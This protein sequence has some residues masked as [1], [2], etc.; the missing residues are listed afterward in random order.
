MFVGIKGDMELEMDKI[1]QQERENLRL[2][3][4]LR[5]QNKDKINRCC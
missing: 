2:L 1:Y 3:L 4:K 5:S